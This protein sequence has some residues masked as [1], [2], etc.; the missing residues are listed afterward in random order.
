MDH[1]Q[2]QG[3]SPAGAGHGLE[4]HLPG[5]KAVHQQEKGRRSQLNRRL[6]I[7]VQ[8]LDG[9]AQDN[10]GR[11]EKGSGQGTQHSGDIPDVPVTA[12][13]PGYQQHAPNGNGRTH[14]F[15]AADGFVEYQ[16]A[17]ASMNTGAM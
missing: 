3:Q 7:G 6:L 2:Q 11:I 16:G 14:Q 8:P 15:P 17:A 5:E 13:H 10:D 12:Q 1:S 9:L 4:I